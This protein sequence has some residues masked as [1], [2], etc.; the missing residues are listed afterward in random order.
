MQ[1]TGFLTPPD[2]GDYLIGVRADGFA[3]VA[4]DGKAVA[5]QFRTHGVEAKAGSVHL[6]KRQKVALTVIYGNMAAGQPATG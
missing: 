5:Q 3:M 6:H 1:W 4:V 2:S